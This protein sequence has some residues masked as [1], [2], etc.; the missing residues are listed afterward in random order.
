MT[1]AKKDRGRPGHN[2]ALGAATLMDFALSNA[3]RT[4]PSSATT[5]LRRNYRY[6]GVRE[7][8]IGHTVGRATRCGSLTLQVANE[9]TIARASK[10]GALQA[11]PI[12]TSCNR[13]YASCEGGRRRREGKKEGTHFFLSHV[14]VPQLTVRLNVWARCEPAHIDGCKSLRSTARM[15]KEACQVRVG[16]KR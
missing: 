2:T 12:L 8:R 6:R 14:A 16:S 4:K 5:R 10:V 15:C 13:A 7:I 9:L 11:I 1:A 3:Q